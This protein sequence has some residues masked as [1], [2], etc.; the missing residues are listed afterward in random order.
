MRVL[1]FR[2]WLHRTEW[3]VQR[4]LNITGQKCCDVGVLRSLQYN[5]TVVCRPK[6]AFVHAGLSST[7]VL[8]PVALGLHQEGLDV[9]ALW[10]V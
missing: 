8:W 4:V 9:V 2:T 7:S 3:E 5:S 1:A 10:K 6:S